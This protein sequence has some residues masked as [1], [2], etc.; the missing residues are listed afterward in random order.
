MEEYSLLA[1]CTA[2]VLTVK[3]TEERN[4]KKIHEKSNMV[5]QNGN[6][7]VTE[8]LTKIMLQGSKGE[9]L[10]IALGYFHA[11]WCVWHFSLNVSKIM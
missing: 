4:K 1:V 10:L 3:P 8:H 11:L 5:S 6:C 2:E 9:E 7:C